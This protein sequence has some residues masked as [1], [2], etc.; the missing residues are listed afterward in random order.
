VIR[1]GRG[2]VRIATIALLALAGYWALLF[3]AQRSLLFPAPR[4]PAHATRPS[5]AQ[6]VWFDVP[7]GRSE[8]WFLPPT[9]GVP[10]PA[11]LLLFTHGNAE[12]IDYWPEAFDGARARGVAVLLLEYPGYG[13]STGR[14]NERSISQAALAAFDWVVT[15]RGV[16]P[17]RIVAYGRSLGGG[18]ACV[19]AAQRRI[20][21]LILE[22]SFTSVRTF[23]RR[24]GAPA[25]LVRDRF[26]NLAAVRAYAGPVLVLHGDRDEVVP[27]AEGRALAAA[28]ARGTLVIRPCGHNDCPSSWEPIARFLEE[29]ALLTR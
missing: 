15:Q 16:D 23:A 6:P 24:Y 8:A 5:E 9:G 21:A 11:P 26:D 20:A 2:V 17:D 27:T 18:P 19:L 13:R 4:A 28:S 3:L 14:P 1:P 29:H 7:G 25:F 10:G 22:S 12:L